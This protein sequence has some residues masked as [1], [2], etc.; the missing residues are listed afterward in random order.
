MKKFLLATTAALSV[1]SFAGIA[2]A[3][4]PRVTVGGFADFQAGWVD[5][6]TDFGAQTRNDGLRNDTEIHFRIDGKTDRGLGYGAVIELEADINDD[7]T[8]SGSNADRTYVYLDGD[9]WGRIEMGGNSDAATALKVDAS[10]IARATGGV[11]GDWFRFAGLPTASFIVRPDLPVSHGG[12]STPGSE[13]NAT[14]VTYY[15]PTFHGFQAGVS[16][17]T[18]SGQ[19]GQTAVASNIG[20]N[21][22]DIFSGGVSYNHQFD[23][24]GLGLSLTTE[25]GDRE[26]NSPASGLADLEAYAGGASVNFRGF[27][28]A[29]SYGNTKDSLGAAKGYDGDFWTAGAAYEYQAFGVSVSYLDSTQESPAGDNDFSNLSFGADYAAAPGL[30]PYVEVSMFD[31]SGATAATSNDGTVFIVGTQLAF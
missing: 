16:Y 28:L 31:F 3:D 15:T 8:G 25:Q 19:R 13:E 27:S 10:S 12:L 30:T 23:E 2:A 4:A 29:G 11:D 24:V 14:K 21:F 22:Q 6:D 18:D 7:T 17:T 5:Q 20:D 26:T 1:A 9:K